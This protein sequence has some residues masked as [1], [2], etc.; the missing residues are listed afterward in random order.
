MTQIVNDDDYLNALDEELQENSNW[1][2]ILLDET[3]RLRFVLTKKPEYMEDS[4]MGQP[5][6]VWKTFYSVIDLNSSNQKERI[7]KANTASTR[8]INKALRMS[9]DLVLD[10]THEGT[11]SNTIYRPK[12]VNPK[13][14]ERQG[15]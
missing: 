13:E 2:K 9:K 3:K 1:I 4:Y 14:T 5:T 8:L 10:I 15:N 6:G 12:I 7:F 11:G